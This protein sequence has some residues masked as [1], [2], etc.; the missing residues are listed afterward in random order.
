MAYFDLFSGSEY[1]FASPFEFDNSTNKIITGLNIFKQE[2]HTANKIALDRIL[3]VKQLIALERAPHVH[4]DWGSAER[5]EFSSFLYELKYANSING[6]SDRELEEYRRRGS[7]DVAETIASVVGDFAEAQYDQLANTVELDLIAAILDLKSEST[8]AGQGSIDYLTLAGATARTEYVLDNANAANIF[9]QL[10]EIQRIQNVKLGGLNTKR[11]G[12][13][14]LA[15]GEAADALHYHQSIKDFTQYSTQFASGDNL[16]TQIQGNNPAYESW[17]L[18]GCT[19]IDVTGYPQF[20][21]RIGEN[22]FVVI[23]LMSQDS[24]AYVLHTGTGRRHATLGKAAQL[25]NQYIVTDPKWGYPEVATESSWL[26]IVNI[27]Q[28]IVFGSLS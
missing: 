1:Q 5:P 26:P 15:A 28:A 11:T 16:F 17:Q 4:S 6:V 12:T 10:S 13:L 21:D 25:Y 20:T 24:N 18:K 3:D 8:Y 23:P 9:Q 22:G 14:I 7:L 2:N 27:P 19:V